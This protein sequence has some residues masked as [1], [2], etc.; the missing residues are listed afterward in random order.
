[1]I[2]GGGERLLVEGSDRRSL[3]EATQASDRRWRGAIAVRGE[4]SQ[5]EGSD[6]WWRGAIAGGG[7]QS[8]VEASIGVWSVWRVALEGGGQRSQVGE[9]VI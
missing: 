5:M 1:M 3:V 9:S 4:R 2:S 8:Q 6:G 7:V